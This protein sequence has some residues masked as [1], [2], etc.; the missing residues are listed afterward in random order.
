MCAHHGS[1]GSN[2]RCNNCSN[3]ST[4]HA[5]RDRPQRQVLL[6]AHG[7]HQG[8]GCIDI[9]KIEHI[10]VAHS[11]QGAGERTSVEKARREPEEL[12][13]MGVKFAVCEASC[14]K[15]SNKEQQSGWKN[16]SLP[17]W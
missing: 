13:E 2:N 7:V 5:L 12:E 9:V 11:L 6:V 17:V 10:K 4:G 14:S 16:A 1:S 3:A 15:R 8:K